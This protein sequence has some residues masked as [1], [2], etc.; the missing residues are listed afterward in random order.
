MSESHTSKSLYSFFILA[1]NTDDKVVLL[2]VDQEMKDNQMNISLVNTVEAGD[3]SAEK[4][5][6]VIVQDNRVSVSGDGTIIIFNIHNLEDKKTQKVSDKITNEFI[7]KSMDDVHFKQVEEKAE[8]KEESKEEEPKEEKEENSEEPPKVMSIDLL[9]EGDCDLGEL[10]KLFVSKPSS[11]VSTSTQN[12]TQVIFEDNFSENTGSLDKLNLNLFY[13]TKSI[14]DLNSMNTEKEVEYER[15]EEDAVFEEPNGIDLRVDSHTGSCVNPSY[16]P[17]VLLDPSVDSESFISNYPRPTIIFKE[18]QNLDFMPLQF[19]ISSKIHRVRSNADSYPIGAGLVFCANSKKEF[20]NIK[21][22][23]PIQTREQYDKWLSKRKEIKLPFREGEP[24]GFF[25]LGNEREVTVKFDQQRVSKYILLCP[26]DFRKKPIKFT[27]R[28]YSNNSEIESFKVVGKIARLNSSSASEETF[29]AKVDDSYTDTSS[30]A[31][32]EIKKNGQW[33]KFSSIDQVQVNY[34]ESLSKS[35]CISLL[36]KLESC[37]TCK[38]THTFDLSSI[39]DQ[40]EGIRVVVDLSSQDKNKL[41]QFKSGQFNVHKYPSHLDFKS[42]GLQRITEKSIQAVYYNDEKLGDHVKKLLEIVS[43]HSQIESIRTAILKHIISL[44]SPVVATVLKENFDYT[45]YLDDPDLFSF[46]DD[47]KYTILKTINK[48]GLSS[49]GSKDQSFF[50]YIHN[51]LHQIQDKGVSNF[52]ITTI[53]LVYTLVREANKESFQKNYELLTKFIFEKA[54][55][56][57]EK[58]NEYTE[59]FK[60]YHLST[61]N[62]ISSNVL[63]S[64]AKN[65][66]YLTTGFLTNHSID[67][68]KL[69]FDYEPQNLLCQMDISVF[70]VK[71]NK[72]K[73]VFRKLYGD[74]VYQMVTKEVSKDVEESHLNNFI[75]IDLQDIDTVSNCYK[76]KVNHI[77]VTNIKN[78]GEIDPANAI[79]PL[80][81]GQDTGVKA[82]LNEEYEKDKGTVKQNSN[83]L[84][85]TLH[86]GGIEY[87]CYEKEQT[88]LQEKVFQKKEL[89][90]LKEPEYSQKLVSEKRKEQLET[91]KVR[92]YSKANELTAVIKSIK[93]KA[94]EKRTKFNNMALSEV[95]ILSSEIMNYLAS[96]ELNKEGVD[97]GIAHLSEKEQ[98][99]LLK[100]IVEWFLL[101]QEKVGKVI[102]LKSAHKISK[103]IL[104]KIKNASSIFFDLIERLI[105]KKMQNHK[106]IF[107]TLSEFIKELSVT[108]VVVELLRRLGISTELEE[109]DIDSHEK[110]NEICKSGEVTNKN[111][112]WIIVGTLQIIAKKLP[113]IERDQK[114]KCLRYFLL[115]GTLRFKASEQEHTLFYKL[116]LNLIKECSRD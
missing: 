16:H 20:E 9:K 63:V 111:K 27:K 93:M 40:L 44:N 30:S 60:T 99:D 50:T 12:G 65:E 10:D 59:L 70:E 91:I 102:S 69:L 8:S 37:V 114:E 76:I 71:N 62:H 106:L 5:Y 100:N 29:Q 2:Q 56:N 43:D 21:K 18:H 1:V 108:D 88:Y 112:M 11:I 97:F 105:E 72:E 96:D 46:S 116:L 19:T 80:Y 34:I 109:T 58:S 94:R 14:S 84:E 81:Y 31:I 115:L 82:T 75:I 36:N 35:Y 13:N 68:I 6:K 64:R 67:Y 7:S 98:Y 41:W 77:H 25:Y 113:K 28:F 15:K 61:G 45:N 4:S 90:A 110:L 89:K 103:K 49:P 95:L 87:V 107:S 79:V 78:A 101:P 53:R 74:D 42:K 57:L 85:E 24:A 26:T 22:Y 92:D 55:P 54:L 104:Q 51:L 83:L 48:M 86:L 66:Y 52:D 33:T 73:L 47:F 3:L 32:V 23:Y 17:S 38:Y 39:R